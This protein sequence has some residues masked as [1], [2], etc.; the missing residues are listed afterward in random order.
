[1]KKRAVFFVLIGI[2]WVA[3]TCF[4]AWCTRYNFDHRGETAATLCV[5]CMLEIFAVVVAYF[6]QY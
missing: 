6:T 5:I 1:M 4:C 3:L 2:A